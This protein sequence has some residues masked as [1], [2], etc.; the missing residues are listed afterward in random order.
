M[1]H[2]IVNAV[3]AAFWTG[4]I[5]L[6]AYEWRNYMAGMNERCR[7]CNRPADFRCEARQVGERRKIKDPKT[8]EDKAIQPYLTFFTC[9]DCTAEAVAGDDP[10]RKVV[11]L[12]H[13]AAAIARAHHDAQQALVGG[14]SIEEVRLDDTW[15]KR[16]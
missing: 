3:V 11:A 12:P 16:P 9:A 6:F 1:R 13:H 14:P 7:D 2:L 15:G 8:G 5:V 10:P 4:L